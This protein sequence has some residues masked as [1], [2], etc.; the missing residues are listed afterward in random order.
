MSF[1]LATSRKRT[2]SFPLPS[3][4]A[5]AALQ[6]PCVLLSAPLRMWRLVLQSSNSASLSAYA[7]CGFKATV[8]DKHL[9]ELLSCHHAA[10]HRVIV[11]QPAHSPHCWRLTTMPELPVLYTSTYPQ[12]GRL[13]VLR[14]GATVASSVVAGYASQALSTTATRRRGSAHGAWRGWCRP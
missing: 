12:R 6:V 4:A 2:A 10:L 11:H 1:A 14:L 7:R 8:P 3:P 5:R 13:C 9:N